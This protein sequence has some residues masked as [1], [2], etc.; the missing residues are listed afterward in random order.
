[1]MLS[2]TPTVPQIRWPSPLSITRVRAPAPLLPS[3]MRTL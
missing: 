3:R 2:L 1:M